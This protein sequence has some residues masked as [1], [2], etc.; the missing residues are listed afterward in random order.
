ML[1][2]A[3]MIS[4]CNSTE[5]CMKW[6]W[7]DDMNNLGPTYQKYFIMFLRMIS[8]WECKMRIYW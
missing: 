6:E 8:T 7:D 5:E 1:H 3:C 2:A 4:T